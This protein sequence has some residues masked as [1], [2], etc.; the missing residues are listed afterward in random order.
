MT[1]SKGEMTRSDLKRKTMEMFG[2]FSP[3]SRFHQLEICRHLGS[4]CTTKKLKGR[5]PMRQFMMTVIAL[6]AFG[7]MV[8]TAQAQ[9]PG[10]APDQSP[11]YSDWAT[12]ADYQQLFNA[13]VK[14]HRYPRVVEAGVF[15]GIVLYH[16]VFERYPAGC[17]GSESSTF[18][19]RSH[20]GI[21]PE[22][23]ALQDYSLR[24]AGF[25]LIHKQSVQLGEREFI[26]ATW[27]CAATGV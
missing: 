13:M 8:V 15:D 2:F 5:Q 24:G 16:A 11:F 26:Q 23:F 9:T 18:R 12:G 25:T 7:A 17:L 3:K 19:F 21:T 14:Q 10:P 6:A 27:V 4:G 20:H 1:P 22:R